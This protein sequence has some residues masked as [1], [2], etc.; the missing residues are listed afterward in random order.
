MADEEN[1]QSDKQIHS[2]KKVEIVSKIISSILIAGLGVYLTWLYN[3]R[4]LE[5]ERI[6]KDTAME[7]EKILRESALQQEKLLEQQ[8]IDTAKIKAIREFIPHLVSAND[9]E[10]KA[11]LLV[12]DSMGYGDFVTRFANSE[13]S[14][15][16]KEAGDIV[17]ARPEL[18]A[19][20][21]V[22][23]NT[24]EKQGVVI[25]WV[26]LGAWNSSAKKWNS[27]YFDYTVTSNPNDDRFVGQTIETREVTSSVNVRNAPPNSFGSLGKI[28]GILKPK[29]TAKIVNLE[30]WFNSGYMWA[31]VER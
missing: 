15:G 18:S 10:K 26:Y 6:L 2:W 16:S 23:K 4:S 12:L 22:I 14:K 24:S 30:E 7:Q 29:A 28:Q 25:G 1:S 5:Q 21:R 9:N 19:E 17:M 31:E 3:D 11:A 27:R 20:T 13:Q 8:S